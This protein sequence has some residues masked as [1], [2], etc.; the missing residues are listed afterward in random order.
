M[1]HALCQYLLLISVAHCNFSEESHCCLSRPGERQQG[2]NSA[3]QHCAVELIKGECRSLVI[4]AFLICK[5]SKEWELSLLVRFT[6]FE[7]E[8]LAVWRERTAM[9]EQAKR[10]HYE[11]SVQ[12][13]QEY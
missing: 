3:C 7:T 2:L 6:L 10:L 1:H 9:Q 12:E 4:S 5:R 8:Y 13:H 11:E